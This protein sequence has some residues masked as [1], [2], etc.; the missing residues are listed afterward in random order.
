[1]TELTL[2]ASVREGTGKSVVR[3]LRRQGQVPGIMY[4][5]GESVALQFDTAEAVKL[6]NRLH[7]SERLIAVKIAGGKGRKGNH[8]RHALLKSVQ[9]SPLGKEL[10]HIDFH[11]VDTQ[12]TVQVKVEVR[13]VGESEGE[14]E[15]GVLQ[16][17]TREITVECLPTIIPEVLEVDVSKLGVGDTL[18]VKDIPMP[19]GVSAIEDPEETVLSIVAPMAEE[20]EEVEEVPEEEAE[21]A[22]AEAA[23]AGEAPAGEGG[24]AADEESSSES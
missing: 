10:L 2:D 9:M 21:A 14:R 23:E 6:V 19:E 15:G 7:G 8:T 13:S 1:M 24:A 18:H 12:Q 3:K 20:V 11:E 5:V 4:G 16:T 17:V 22:A